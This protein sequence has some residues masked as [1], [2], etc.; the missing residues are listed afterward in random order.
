METFDVQVNILRPRKNGCHF[1]DDILKCI[2]LNENVWIWLKVSLQLLLKGLV[3]NIPSFVQIM[4]WS[5]PGDKPLSEPMMI[6]LPT[7]ICVTR[8]QWVKRDYWMLP[9]GISLGYRQPRSIY[10]G[11]AL[12]GLWEQAA[13]YDQSHWHALSLWKIWVICSGFDLW[14]C[15]L[16][17]V[18]QYF[19]S[20]LILWHWQ[21]AE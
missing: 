12:D 21:G 5:R 4:A 18:K 10:T 1:P 20:T 14:N 3:D 13:R 2:L 17:P 11:P 16:V 7:H 8:P 15:K 9:V 6:G 19:K